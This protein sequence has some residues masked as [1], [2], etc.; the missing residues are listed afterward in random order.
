[1]S[2]THRDPFRRDCK[3]NFDL[4]PEKQAKF[5]RNFCLSV[6]LAKHVFRGRILP[7][8]GLT[9]NSVTVNDIF[10]LLGNPF[11]RFFICLI[12]GKQRKT[13]GRSNHHSGKKRKSKGAAKALWW[14]RKAHYSIF[15]TSIQFSICNW[16]G[17]SMFQIIDNQ[18][19]LIAFWSSDLGNPTTKSIKPWEDSNTTNERSCLLSWLKRKRLGVLGNWR[20]NYRSMSELCIESLRRLGLLSHVRLYIV[21]NWRVTFFWKI[22]NPLTRNVSD[23]RLCLINKLNF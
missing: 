5:S 1:M 13:L 8:Q 15:N 10:P 3:N 19:K 21:K 17:V 23:L 11:G 16:S 2:Y 20:E 7:W 4:T 12:R 14:L 9:P 6:T 22:N 18:P